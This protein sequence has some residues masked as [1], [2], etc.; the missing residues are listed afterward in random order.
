MGEACKL[1]DYYI[2]FSVILLI[3]ILWIK[4]IKKLT[5]INFFALF[6][7]IISL[8]TIV[9]YDIVYISNDEYES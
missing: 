3:P 7:I 6:M 1:K 8:I 2:I 9:F 5:F 4:T